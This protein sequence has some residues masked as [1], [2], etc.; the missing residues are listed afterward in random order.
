M[1]HHSFEAMIRSFSPQQQ[2]AMY[3]MLDCMIY[4]NDLKTFIDS[5]ISILPEI[6]PGE[7]FMILV[8][9]FKD[10]VDNHVA[11]IG[12][13]DEEIL[14]FQ[15]IRYLEREPLWNMLLQTKRTIS[16]RLMYSDQEWVQTKAC[17][18]LQKPYNTFHF[19][20]APILIH[21][22]T[23]VTIHVNRKAD[24]PFTDQEI[25]N[26]N[27]LSRFMSRAIRS[28]CHDLEIRSF[29]FE[30]EPLTIREKEVVRHLAKGY[31]DK[32][33]AQEM[34][35]SL[36]TVKDHLKNI[37]AKLSVSNRMEAVVTALKHKII[38]IV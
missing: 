27:W 26:I 8:S 19:V 21:K 31:E 24:H 20:A 30:P 6:I 36:Y 3:K 29:P 37:Y 23:S 11:K 5:C 2:S 22:N 4:A 16:N 1:Y 32:Q 15:R 33:I 25:Q 34:G 18:Y 9:N 13:S 17:N 7:S 12:L 10:G 14:R 38:D 28:Y 35:I